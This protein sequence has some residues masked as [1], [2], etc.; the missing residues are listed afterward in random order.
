MSVIRLIQH[1]TEP[2]TDYTS[3]VP[4]ATEDVVTSFQLS[5]LHHVEF[6][7]RQADRL[8][9]RVERLTDRVDQLRGEVTELRRTVDDQ[10]KRLERTERTL[11]MAPD[12]RQQTWFPSEPAAECVPWPDFLQGLSLSDL[13]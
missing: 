5:W 10:A 13:C 11:G 12:G 8:A 4:D 7:L 1:D 6:R 9:D 3:D 2:D